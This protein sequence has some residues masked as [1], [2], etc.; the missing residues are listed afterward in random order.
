MFI[1]LIVKIKNGCIDPEKAE[2]N[3]E[4]FRSSLSEKRRTKWQQKAEEKNKKKYHHY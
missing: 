4:K 3:Q 2:E 1:S